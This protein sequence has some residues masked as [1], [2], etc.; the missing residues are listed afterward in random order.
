[1]PELDT[2]VLK[3]TPEEMKSIR[4]ALQHGIGCPCANLTWR[5]P[6][7]AL[8]VKLRGIEELEGKI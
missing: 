8:L 1:M 7:T 2:P 6:L 3:I 4:W 5:E